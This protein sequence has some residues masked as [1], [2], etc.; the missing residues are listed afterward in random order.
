MGI[1]Q[2]DKIFNM[3]EAMLFIMCITCMLAFECRGVEVLEVDSLDNQDGTTMSD[4]GLDSSVSKV[5]NDT[6]ER[7]R[8]FKLFS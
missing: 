2:L 8:K 7:N 3:R 5:V 4:Q 6:A 1:F